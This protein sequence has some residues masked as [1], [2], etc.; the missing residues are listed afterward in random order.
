MNLL[1]QFYLQRTWVRQLVAVELFP[2]CHRLHRSGDH[3]E[4]QLEAELSTTLTLLRTGTHIAQN[5]GNLI[6]RT[7]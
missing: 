7:G 6:K 1:L 5:I 3:H 4:S 2:L